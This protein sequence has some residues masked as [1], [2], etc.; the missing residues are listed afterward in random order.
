[1]KQKSEGQKL[2]ME[3]AESSEMSVNFYQCT[4]RH[5]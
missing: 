2:M 1:M 5:T 4:R 3:E